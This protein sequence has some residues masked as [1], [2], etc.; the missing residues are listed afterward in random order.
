MIEQRYSDNDQ[1]KRDIP[2][3]IEP[4]PPLILNPFMRPRPQKGTNLME[5]FDEDSVS[6]EP[7]LVQVYLRLKPY[8]GQSNLYEVRSDRCLITS[9]DT[10]TAG[11]GR[12]TEHNISK[13][14]TFS[15]IF[16]AE[17]T[18]KEIFE[19]V[20]K[21]NLKKLPDG[22]S[23]TLLTYGASGSGKTYTLMGTVASPGLVP[24]SLE[25]VFRVV[26]AAQ[27]PV[28][29]PSEGGA[30]KLDY[31][32]Q[33]Y[34]LQWVKRLRQVSAPLRDKYKRMSAGLCS[35]FTASSLDL[36]N[37]TK[38]YVWV[39]FVEIY[40][41]GIY[42][43]LASSD[44]RSSNKLQIREDSNGNVFVKGVTQAF[45]RSGEEA[46]DVMVAG[47]HNLQVA[48]TGI[49]AQSSR[50]HCIFTI[51]MLTETEG[52]ARTASVRLCDLAGCERAR[53]TRNAGARMQESRA[54]N[55]SLHVLERCLHTLRRRRRA[56]TAAAAAAELVPYRESKLTRLLA[57]GLS[58]ARAEAVAMVVTLNPAPLAAPESRHVLQLAAVARDI[59]VNS[60]I[61]EMTCLDSTQNSTIPS[62]AEVMK[63]RADNERLHFELVQAQARNKEL[64]ANMEERQQQAAATMREL[65]DDA[66]DMTRQYYEAQLAAQ[67]SEMDDMIEEYE[68]K[69][70]MAATPSNAE[71]LL[72]QEKVTELMTEIAILE[73]KLTA[74]R[75]ARARAEEEVQHL[76][77]C[78]DERDDKVF[79]DNQSEKRED[80]ML[81]SD[82]EH[83]S[84]EEV[85]DPCNESLEPTFKK[86][87]INRSKLVMQS[88]NSH[89]TSYSTMQDDEHTIDNNESIFD[90]TNDTLKDDHYS[91]NETDKES[92][93]DKDEEIYSIKNTMEKSLNNTKTEDFEGEKEEHESVNKLKTSDFRGTY[94]VKSFEENET[95]NV[96][97]EKVL[98]HSRGIY[99]V[100]NVESDKLKPISILPVINTDIVKQLSREIETQKIDLNIK[101]DNDIKAEMKYTQTDNTETKP[102]IKVSQ[103]LVSKIINSAKSTPGDNS[104]TQFEQLEMAT[105]TCN[106]TKH[107]S[108]E[109]VNIKILKEK[110]TYFDEQPI[111]NENT[112]KVDPNNKLTKT[113]YFMSTKVNQESHMNVDSKDVNINSDC[114]IVKNDLLNDN[115]NNDILRSPSIVKDEIITDNF[116][117]STIK[118]LLGESLTRQ[119]NI[120][121]T[122]K[123]IAVPKKQN[124]VDIFEGFDSPQPH[125]FTKELD[126][127]ENARKSI[128]K[129]VL[130]QQSA[131][132][133][134]K[135]N[136]RKD[137][138]ES[139]SVVKEPIKDVKQTILTNISAVQKTPLLKVEK[140]EELSLNMQ[141]AS[142]SGNNT[143][144]DFENIYKNITAP[145]PTDFD[146]FLSQ[147][148]NISKAIEND[149]IVTQKTNG[150]KVDEIKMETQKLTEVEE[151]KYNLRNKASVKTETLKCFNKD[152]K[153][154]ESEEVLVVSQS[155]CESK[156]KPSK[157]NLR[158]RRRKN[159]NDE[160]K[161]D[162][163]TVSLKDIVNLQTEFSDVTLDVP[164]PVK[165]VKDIP[166]P[167][168]SKFEDENRPPVLEI[169]SC[170]SKSVTRSRRKLFTPRI[171]PLDESM[172]AAGDSNE[173]I[174]V[175][176]PSYHRTRARRKL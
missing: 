15:R 3:F 56:A 86:E 146:V 169:Q 117:P 80:V 158:L 64:L 135:N 170:P 110:R 141:Q 79:G 176:R 2:S 125:H 111:I 85:E 7:E 122:H 30:D 49:H 67:R 68:N 166:S 31:A 70:K 161:S 36:S 53:R 155:K 34:E 98:S 165:I 47:K 6:D 133:V 26:D 154:S 65:V 106:E 82:S 50:S 28:Y 22:H 20:V 73:E 107:I 162:S 156:T 81:V 27:Q 175:P 118:K 61:A 59:Q 19:H 76:R 151:V 163:E 152:H 13:M 119:T 52:V 11:H 153:D 33:E 66:K 144:E 57:A 92:T 149:Q 121:S 128:E 23:F 120:S 62:S 83:D 51:T 39:S 45:V 171:E 145:R 94:C 173:R 159:E 78:I 124:S 55:S 88:L 48:A 167:E 38:Y 4:R 140:T 150:S 142:I 87:D 60:T 32:E 164:A 89:N 5:L 91:S 90:K 160:E 157:R 77:A 112:D 42:D 101:K 8:H 29:K 63:L 113:D 10:A 43:L 21:D 74:E 147:E 75:L 127:I 134:Q 72:L 1:S 16:D 54:I 148:P 138:V 18:Q 137:K 115:L 84:E 17:T 130:A 35:D 96:N 123:N 129:L 131:S 139:E 116:K 108:D 46:Y 99:Y 71:T 174:Y 12:R 104:L 126:V 109:F 93:Y 37:R 132:K 41:E 44:R 69:L 114:N 105:N 143:I 58:G 14:Y 172:G 136:K 95:G 97:E 40:N 24:R 102:N 103:T 168:K 100:N 25:Y 9:V